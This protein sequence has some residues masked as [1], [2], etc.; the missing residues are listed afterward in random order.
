MNKPN[1]KKV[2]ASAK[3]VV[4]KHSPEILTGLGIAGMLTSTVLAV[5]ATPKAVLLLEDKKSELET[6]K[7]SG[8]EVVKTAWK[9]YIPAT[10][11]ATTSTACLIGASSV[12]VKR[13]AALATAY[14]LSQNALT[15][16]KEKVIET[17][18]EK[19]EQNIRDKVAKERVE[20]NPVKNSEVIFTSKG[21]T[22]CL[23]VISKRYFKGDIDKI[24]RA[25][26]E[27]NKRMLN[28]MYVSL[29]DFYNEIGLEQTGIG[30]DLG[31][32]IS[33]DGLIN[34][35]FSSQLTEDDQPCVV[36]DYHIAPRYDYSKL[37]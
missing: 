23:D 30:D 12:N 4:S 16:Y 31:W 7:L 34:L 10:V 26:N 19:K 5:R 3:T 20:K 25:E 13:N 28:E 1:F 14:Q 22:L 6:D 15:E 37:M 24:K 17:I 32:N 2:I 8:I 21:D 29:N 35:E 36:I 18:G 9:C 27:L 11:L 33:R